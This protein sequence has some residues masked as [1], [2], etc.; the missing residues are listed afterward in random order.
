[1]STKNTN[2]NGYNG[3]LGAILWGIIL[4]SFSA[5]IITALRNTICTI[6][7]TD[8]FSIIPILTL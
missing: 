2:Q 7:V 3:K 8:Y 1:M 4:S 5:V 6:T